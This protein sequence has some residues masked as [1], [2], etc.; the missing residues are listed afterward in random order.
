LPVVGSEGEGATPRPEPDFGRILAAV[1]AHEIAEMDA[2]AAYRELARST[3]DPVI[4]SL[5]RVLLDDEEHHHR[6]FRGITMNL[7]AIAGGARD[8]R[9]MP[10]G[11][12]PPGCLDMLCGFARQERDGAAELRAL[13]HEGD[14]LFGG[15]FALLL[16]LI[17]MDSAKHELILGFIVRELEEAQE[18][19][20]R[21][22]V[23]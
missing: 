20:G 8:Q 3:R 5:L 21:E 13:A 4:A 17:A 6:V 1:Q 15:I 9:T 11:V 10:L 2:V 23:A 16:K 22:T 7:R 19:R 12:P 14:G 18:A